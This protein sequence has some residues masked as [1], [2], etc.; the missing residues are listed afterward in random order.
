[1]K[2]LV[3]IVIVIL[4]VFGIWKWL[5]HG[6]SDNT[7]TAEASTYKIGVIAP[8]TGDA[9]AYGEPARNIYQIAVDEINAA[10]GINGKKLELD[11]QDSK[12]DGQDGVSATQ[13]LVSSDGVKVIIGGMCS[14]E[15]IPSVP[16]AAGSKVVILS[17][18]ASSSALTNISP[19]FVR[20]Y[21]SDAGQGQTLATGAYNKNWKKVVII[22]EETD[23]A[24]A[25]DKAFSDKFT[26]LGGTVMT[27]QFPTNTTD[28]RTIVTKAKGD[29][30]DGVF[31]IAQ[32]IASAQKVFKAMQD[33]KWSP[34]III[35]E[36]LAGDIQTL[37]TYKTLLEGSMAAEYGGEDSSNPKFVDLRDKY[38]SKYGV[39]A[40]YLSSYAQTEYDAVYMV[41]DAIAAVGYDGTKIA[42]FLRSV[43]NWP[44]ASGSVTIGSDG[45]RVG[46]FHLEMVKNGQIIQAQ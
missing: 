24:T 2:K 20:D 37:S 31:V 39:D 4:V 44:G 36:V 13:K 46:G 29:N 26:S 6:S 11:S 18:G 21:P 17:P 19:Y 9:A 45:D 16:V 22:Q 7:T 10:G 3:T 25:L 27:E 38:K 41:R 5:G 1:M 23:Y 35:N 28:F 14:G 40:P 34:K 30:A 42:Q 15:T 32:T 43:K 8:L 33:L 12:C